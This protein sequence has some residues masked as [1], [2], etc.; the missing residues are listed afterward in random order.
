MN[1]VELTDRDG[2]RYLY[3]FDTGWEIYDKGEMPAF[4]SNHREGRNMNARETP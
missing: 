3:D 2:S 4:W 1:F